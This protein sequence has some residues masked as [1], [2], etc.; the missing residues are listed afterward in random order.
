VRKLEVIAAEEAKVAEANKARAT[1]VERRNSRRG[2][3]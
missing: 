2:G 1:S 3:A